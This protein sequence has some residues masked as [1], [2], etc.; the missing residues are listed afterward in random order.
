V[1]PARIEDIDTG[2]RRERKLIKQ[3]GTE[4]IEQI[5]VTQRVFHEPVTEDVAV[6]QDV[7]AVKTTA[8]VPNNDFKKNKNGLL[9]REIIE[10][11]QF[12]TEED[13]KRFIDDTAKAQRKTLLFSS[14]GKKVL[15]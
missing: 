5:P 14:D 12:A 10:E 8:R 2:D 9:L 15:R 1:R 7:F 11:H 6:I 3:D 13:A 4:I